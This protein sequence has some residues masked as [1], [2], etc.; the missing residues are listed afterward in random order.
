[1]DT[2]RRNKM[3]NFYQQNH[4]YV[5]PKS[6]RN[7]SEEKK[8]RNLSPP[9]EMPVPEGK[10]KFDHVILMQHNTGYWHANVTAH[11]AGC[12]TGK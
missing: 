3:D 5:N 11:L 8:Q 9:R 1:M 10:P 6:E 4:K 12:F 7:T 2:E